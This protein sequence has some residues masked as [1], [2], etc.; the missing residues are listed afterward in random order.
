MLCV[1][2]IKHSQKVTL[3]GVLEDFQLLKKSTYKELD[4]RIKELEKRLHGMQQTPHNSLMERAQDTLGKKVN[5]Q[6]EIINHITAGI[7][8]VRATDGVIVY[9]N[10]MFEHMF[11][12]EAEEMIGK[13]VSVVNAPTEKSP[14]ET[15]IEIMQSISQ[16]GF[17]SG[18]VYNQKKDGTQ[19]WCHA[20]VSEFYHNHFGKVLVSIHEDITKTKLTQLKL[21]RIQEELE[22]SHAILERRVEER[23]VELVETNKDLQNEVN[24]RK[25]STDA[26]RESELRYRTLFDNAGVGIGVTTEDGRIVDVNHTMV[27]MLGYTLEEMN[28]KN[29]VDLYSNPEEISWLLEQYKMKGF[30]RDVEAKMIHN[31]GNLVNVILTVTS[32]VLE[33]KDVLLIVITDITERKRIDE[34]ILLLSNAIEQSSEGVVVTDMKGKL[35]YLNSSFASM[36]GYEPNELLGKNIT[37]CHTTE[38]L[39]SLETT[40]QQIKTTGY[41]K[42]ELWHLHRD[43]TVFPSQMSNSLIKDNSGVP[44]TMLSTMVDITEIYRFKDALLESEEIF[45]E[46]YMSSPVGLVMLDDEFRYLKVN[47]VLARQNGFSVEEHIGKSIYDLLDSDFADTIV[48]SSQAL[49]QKDE[50]LSYEIEGNIPGDPGIHKWLVTA[51]P[52]HWKGNRG[53]GNVV[54]EITDLKQKEEEIKQRNRDLEL[55]F[56]L[57]NLVR[58][59]LNIEDILDGVLE[60]TMEAFGMDSGAIYLPDDATENLTIKTH[61]GCSDTFIQAVKT[62]KKENTIA[63]TALNTA[64]PMIIQI[65]NHPNPDLKAIATAEGLNTGLVIPLISRERP[66]GTISLGNKETRYFSEEEKRLAAS[67]SLQVSKSLENVR[68][69]ESLKQSSEELEERVKTRTHELE[70]AK[71]SVTDSLRKLNSALKKSEFKTAEL[72]AFCYSVSHDLKAPLR[73]I[74]GYSQL[75]EDEYHDQLDEEGRHFLGLV[76]QSASQMDRLINDLLTYSRLDRMDINVEEVD[77]SR[78]FDELLRTRL[79]SLKKQ[80]FEVDLHLAVKKVMSETAGLWHIFDNFIDNAIK[81]STDRP[82][83]SIRIDSWEEG[84]EWIFKVNDTGIGFDMKYHDR[85]F[86]I[87]QRLGK[88]EEYPGTG[89]GLAIVKKMVDRLEGRV[90]GESTPGQGTSFYVALPIH[91][92]SVGVA[93][94]NDKPSDPQ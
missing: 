63:D 3:F 45:N 60:I 13:H 7:Y 1:D 80:G 4:Q 51:F 82:K 62:I 88:A 93:A 29:I 68:L 89:V 47:D 74:E 70:V 30:I 76:R 22:K 27:D 59:Q 65:E 78:L 43:G 54:M 33:R 92:L 8:L 71:E 91:R 46:F 5:F 2:N 25:K 79:S 42:G 48:S 17:W 55:L 90:W 83:P 69:Y 14:K 26:L 50:P 32:V 28:Y 64:A 73:G 61:K 37:I 6:D 20:N 49:L 44:I 77:V 31:N 86:T 84:G 67:I 40:N 57:E 23:T 66:Y 18:D 16:D 9:A 94:R 85:I 52:I 36:H 34:Q 81:F 24:V 56:S 10:P 72:D 19:F 11:G 38:Q 53:I 21:E 39:S 75:L 58:Q 15:A 41:L 35:L 12:Y 87:F